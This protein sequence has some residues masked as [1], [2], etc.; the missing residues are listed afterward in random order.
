LSTLLQET[1]Q[2]CQDI[3]SV[4]PPLPVDVRQTRQEHED[5]GFLVVADIMDLAEGHKLAAD[6]GKFPYT[7]P[8]LDPDLPVDHF[9]DFIA[10]DEHNIAALVRSY[11]IHMNHQAHGLD[12]GS[13]TAFGGSNTKNYKEDRRQAQHQGLARKSLEEYLPVM[14]SFVLFYIRYSMVDPDNRPS[15]FKDLPSLPTKTENLAVQL[16][17]RTRQWKGSHGQSERN[18]RRIVCLDNLAALIGSIFFKEREFGTNMKDRPDHIFLACLCFDGERFLGG[19]RIKGQ[20]WPVVFLLRATIH[21]Y[22]LRLEKKNGDGGFEVSGQKGADCMIAQLPGNPPEPG[23]PET[24]SHRDVY[25]FGHTYLSDEKCTTPL[26]EYV[27]TLRQCYATA[28]K[29]PGF[30]KLWFNTDFRIHGD[31]TRIT[32]GTTNLY[33]YQVQHAMQESRFNSNKAFSTLMGGSKLGVAECDRFFATPQE[34]RD[35]KEHNYH[36]KRSGYS[37]I[38]D[39]RNN[40][41][42][43]RNKRNELLTEYIIKNHMHTNDD[44]AKVSRCS[45]HCVF[46]IPLM[47]SYSLFLPFSPSPIS[48]PLTH[49]DT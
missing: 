20:G 7:N 19:H 22:R 12:K 1:L 47:Q 18:Q 46:G 8:E 45:F 40:D 32:I 35:I 24:R 38:T 28:N 11:A 15:F 34:K 25:R 9:L 23:A 30:P 16:V 4:Q 13:K 37:F 14:I 29:N 6:P 27:A 48:I 5:A 3:L 31:R 26:T 42:N 41:E 33:L 21:Y 10:N 43:Q 17:Q 49:P 39:L 36:D 2:E 44:A